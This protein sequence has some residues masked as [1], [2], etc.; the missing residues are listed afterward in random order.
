M[1]TCAVDAHE[2]RDIMTINIPNAYIQVCVPEEK[3]GERT[4]MKI[5]GQLVDWLCEIDPVSYL[6][7]VVYENEVKTLYLWVLKAIY[8]MLKAGLL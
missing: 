6:P 7:F 3:K 5:R 8:G 1:L 4:I 2:L